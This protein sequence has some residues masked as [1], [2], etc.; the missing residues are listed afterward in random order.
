MATIVAEEMVAMVVIEGL[1]GNTKVVSRHEM[2][3]LA[4]VAQW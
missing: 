4:G 1:A 3:D 2:D